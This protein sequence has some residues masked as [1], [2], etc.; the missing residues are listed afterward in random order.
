MEARN[1]S[2]QETENLAG[3]V[4]ESLGEPME[5]AK[6]V[7]DETNSDAREDGGQDDLPD[8]IKERLARQERKHQREM[9]RLR[10][11]MNDMHARM[12]PP[13]NMD[14]SSQP[15]NPYDT[16]D[17]GIDEQ[18]HKAVSYALQHKEMSERKAKE[19]ESVAHVHRKIESLKNHLDGMNDKYE[20]F[21]EVV[22][23]RS[24]PF[25][26]AMREALLVLPHKGAG[27]AGEVLYKLAKNRSELERISKLH[28]V[29]QAEEVVALSHSLRDEK[30]SSPSQHR[31]MGQ[32]KTNPVTNS[33]AITEKTP[34]GDI[35]R[36]M[37]SGGWK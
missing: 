17:G 31:L 22:M 34:V 12:I 1:L 24:M 19:A 25:T 20:D 15:I 7:V 23:D 11:Q 21:H 36:R 33:A 16:G 6:E 10:E 35:R 8:G 28:P 37:K 29:D 2:E 18:I 30:G 14:E 9:K 5:A 4:M 27:S 3:E 26:S 13:N 32:V